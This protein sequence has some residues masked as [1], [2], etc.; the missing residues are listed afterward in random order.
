MKAELEMGERRDAWRAVVFLQKK[1]E[2]QP[3]ALENGSIGRLK[4]LCWNI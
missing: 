3:K 1:E 4:M 2:M